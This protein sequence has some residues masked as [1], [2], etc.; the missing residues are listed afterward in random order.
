MIMDFK[1]VKLEEERQVMKKH[2]DFFFPHLFISNFC[3][4]QL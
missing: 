3:Q 4:L 1:E 2:S